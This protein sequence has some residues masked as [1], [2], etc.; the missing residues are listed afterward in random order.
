MD[1]IGIVL[2]LIFATIVVCMLID[3]EVKHK[4]DLYFMGLFVILMI[5]IDSYVWINFGYETFM[6]LYTFLAQIPLYIAFIF[7]SKYK[8]IKLAF[9]HLTVIALVSSI[10]LIAI[11]ISSFFGLSLEIMYV[12]SLI[13]YIPTGFITYRYFRPYILYMLRNTDKGWLG[14]CVLP[15]TYSILTYSSGKYNLGDV[16]S[17]NTLVPSIRGLIFTIV[18]YILILW[19]FKQTREQLTLQNEQNLLQMQITA[20]KQNLEALKES[21]E[22][23]IIYRHDMRHHLN[24]INAYLADNNKEAAQKYITEVEKS[25]DSITVE[26][27]CSNY[28]LNLIMHFYVTKAKKEHI[29]VETHIELPK[30]LAISD[31][32]LCLV[33]SNAIENAINALVNIESTNDKILKIICKTKK[34]KLFIKITNSFEGTVMFVDKIPINESENHGIGTKS[35]A[36]IAEKY[37]GVCSFTSENGIFKTNIIL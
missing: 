20:S 8:G 4:K 22:K 32:D 1:L 16:I 7:V 19:L 21:Q 37:N 34:D 24:L 3:F 12:I 10:V 23:T 33:F 13:L 15:L 26:T 30:Q 31:M 17:Q 35:I 28:S 2:T 5:V 6:K 9:V 29:E 27:Y 11:L 18:S 25:I 36:A 14:F